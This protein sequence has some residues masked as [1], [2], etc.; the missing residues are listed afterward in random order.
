MQKI[1]N[2]FFKKIKKYVKL[3]KKQS[4]RLTF[5]MACNTIKL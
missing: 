3:Q 1:K 4:I 2:I 5:Y